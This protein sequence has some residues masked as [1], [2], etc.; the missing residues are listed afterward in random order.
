VT[1]RRLAGAAVVLLLLAVYCAGALYH[2]HRVN[3]DVR[4]TDQSAY[5]D[6]AR[7]TAETDYAFVGGRNRMHVYPFLLSLLY[8][9]GLSEEAFFERAKYMN[10]ALS[11]A[12][13]CAIWA[14]LRLWLPAL[15]AAALTPVAAFSVFVY[16]A[17]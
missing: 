3:V 14:M 13:L 1:Q 15:E 7:N 16:K 2:L 10:V 17:A 6:C 8:E 11:I 9:H 4:R 5:L 12:V